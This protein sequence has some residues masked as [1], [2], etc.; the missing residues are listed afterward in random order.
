MAQVH[1]GRLISRALKRHGTSHLFT[2][3]GGH[4]QH[5]YDGCLDFG[6]RVVDVRHEPVSYTHLR[7]H[8]T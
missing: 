1:G 8:E 7:A 5:I 2:L 6:I 4:I 3:C